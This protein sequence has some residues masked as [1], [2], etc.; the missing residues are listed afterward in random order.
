MDWK[1]LN[2]F[3]FS[4]QMQAP[5]PMVSPEEAALIQASIAGEK[6]KKKL[7]EP[8]PT[9]QPEPNQMLSQMSVAQDFSSPEEAAIQRGL[10]GDWKKALAD[11]T[12]GVAS[13][14]AQLEELKAKPGMVNLSPFAALADKWA[15]TKLAPVAQQMA[16]MS[17][18]EKAVMT[19]KLTQALN[20]NKLATAREIGD[21]LSRAQAGESAKMARFG[22]SQDL[23]KEDNLRNDITKSVMAPMQEDKQNLDVMEA[24]LMS[25]DYAQVMNTLSNYSRKVAGEKGVLTD[26]DIKRVLPGNFQGDLAR[27]QS[28]FNST[29]TEQIPPEYTKS[30]RDLMLLTKQKLSERYNQT[31]KSKGSIYKSGVYRNLMQPGYVGDIIFKEAESISKSF[32]TPEA[33]KPKSKLDMLLED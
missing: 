9:P 8:V 13:Q 10:R 11:Y 14:E 2:Q 26:Q 25:G 20:Q 5:S 33:A 18:E 19:Q 1:F 22:L 16:G 31:L 24:A 3:G 23:K 7:L 17:Q 12:Q 15:G 30:M 21:Q 27:F 32:Y 29:P 4:D 28:Y 6:K